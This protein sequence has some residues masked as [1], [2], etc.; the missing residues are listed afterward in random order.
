MLIESTHLALSL[1]SYATLD[2]LGL[3]VSMVE[4]VQDV[5]ATFAN[6]MS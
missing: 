1:F 3:L 5:G 2:F 4:G 6:L